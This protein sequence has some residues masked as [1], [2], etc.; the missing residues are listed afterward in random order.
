MRPL[1]AAAN[2]VFSRGPGCDII[3]GLWFGLTA[4]GISPVAPPSPA[5]GSQV[6]LRAEAG[7]FFRWRF[8]T[9]DHLLNAHP[10]FLSAPPGGTSLRLTATEAAVCSTCRPAPG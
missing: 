4:P 3:L 7:Q 2:P 10:F 8:L 6:T 1:R 5:A 9:P